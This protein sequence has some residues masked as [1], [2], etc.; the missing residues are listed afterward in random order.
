[1]T[2]LAGVHVL[3]VEDE[4][5]VAML[6]E[7]M[8][9]DLGC[10]VAGTAGRVARALDLVRAGGFQMAILD[11]NVAGENVFPVAEALAVRNVPFVFVTGYGENGVPDAFR[12]RP[13]LQKPLQADQLEQALRQALDAGRS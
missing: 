6:I 5:L 1:M 8:V 10:T 3:V 9:A 12:N 4:T 7:D 2:G 13:V 11:V